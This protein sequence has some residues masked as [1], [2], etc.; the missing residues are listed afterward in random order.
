M[1]GTLAVTVGGLLFLFTDNK[2]GTE[3]MEKSLID[4]GW[5]LQNLQEIDVADLF[6]CANKT[7]KS[8]LRVCSHERLKLRNVIWTC[9]NV[10]GAVIFDGLT[11]KNLGEKYYDFAVHSVWKP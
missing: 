5:Q 4:V 10:N 2:L 7:H 11:Q 9:M 6:L 8:T 3:C 1:A